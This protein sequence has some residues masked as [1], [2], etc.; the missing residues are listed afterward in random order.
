MFTN[1]KVGAEERSQEAVVRYF[2]LIE[3]TRK[4][5]PIIEWE[6]GNLLESIEKVK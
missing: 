2:N 6:T 5:L 1:R 4:L 3:S